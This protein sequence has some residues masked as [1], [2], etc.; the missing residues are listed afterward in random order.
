MTLSMV[1]PLTHQVRPPHTITRVSEYI[2]EIGEFV[3]QVGALIVYRIRLAFINVTIAS[4]QVQPL[5][6][7]GSMI[8]LDKQPIP[9]ISA[10]RCGLVVVSRLRI[11]PY[12]WYRSYVYYTTNACLSS[13]AV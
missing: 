7:W 13:W 9:P 6:Q 10:F 3:L 8:P 2:D 12:S 5:S 11:F 1:A 4:K